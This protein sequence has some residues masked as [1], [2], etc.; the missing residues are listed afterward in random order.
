[1]NR[2]RDSAV[3]KLRTNFFIRILNSYDSFLKTKSMKLFVG[4]R[5]LKS[6]RSTK[7]TENDVKD[8]CLVLHG[9]IYDEKYYE[10]LVENLKEFRQS[11][12][13]LK[14]IVVTYMDDY[15]IK[16]EKIARELD[17]E[18]T[19]SE[20]VG[21]LPD[22]YPRSLGQQIATISA[23]VERARAL[24]F[25][26]VA[27]LRV[28]QSVELGKFFKVANKMIELFPPLNDEFSTRIWSTSY[29]SY[30]NRI[31]G[32]SDMFM[33]GSTDIM[34][35]F[36]KFSAPEDIVKFNTNSKNKE[37]RETL[38]N[39]SIP[40]TWLGYRF[41]NSI[42]GESIAL[43]NL[44]NEFW[45]KYAGVVNSEAIGFSWGKSKDWF[46]TNF[47]SINWFGTIYSPN[48]VELRFEEWLI[49]NR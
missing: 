17:I 38:Y 4:T 25:K 21:S 40:E 48:L 11:S 29:N 12:N 43:K 31:L 8:W 15:F 41:M 2:F 35:H 49:K 44:D 26:Y 3:L 34:S 36:W 7:V 37:A 28:D 13:D 46:A 19:S 45:N 18:L 47:H 22:P 33:F 42:S 5:E 24:N 20:D 6:S 14:I 23:G 10:Y 1:M 32:I 30:S 16:L 27:K 9:K 39:F